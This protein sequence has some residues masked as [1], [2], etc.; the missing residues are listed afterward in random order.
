MEVTRRKHRRNLDSYPAVSRRDWLAD[1]DWPELAELRDEHARLLD[2]RDA[3]GVEL[4][5]ARS[6]FESEDNARTSALRDSFRSG[7]NADELPPLTS[8]QER[9]AT[10]APLVERVAAVLDALEEFV[11][12]TLARFADERDEWFGQLA[13][14]EDA[15]D[16]KRAEARRLLREA[17][18]QVAESQRLRMWIDRNSGGRLGPVNWGSLPTPP[19]YEQDALA[20]ADAEDA[21]YVREHNEQL[22]R[23]RDAEPGI[24]VLN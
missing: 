10:L 3:A 16:A 18:A 20:A 5:A 15:A 24:E 14:V 8:P 12:E 22:R 23:E 7:G 11:G 17:D 21:L 13:T 9:A 2:S 19:V 4:A 1:A 6:R